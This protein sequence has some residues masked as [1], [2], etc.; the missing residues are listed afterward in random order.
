MALP[1]EVAT[2]PYARL[3]PKIS[4]HARDAALLDLSPATYPTPPFPLD[5]VSKS[6]PQFLT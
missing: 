2:M 6:L 5:L 3:Q 4:K 1:N